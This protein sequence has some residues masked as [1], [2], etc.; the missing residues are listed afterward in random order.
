MVCGLVTFAPVELNERVSNLVVW[1]ANRVVLRPI[2]EE[3]AVG[4]EK[5]SRQKS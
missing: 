3:D 2:V 1:Y 5:V 4:R